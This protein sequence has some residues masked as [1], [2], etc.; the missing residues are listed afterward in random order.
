MTVAGVTAG[1]ASIKSKSELPVKVGAAAVLA[2]SV[3]AGNVIVQV[4]FFSY[5]NGVHCPPTIPAQQHQEYKPL[6]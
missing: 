2:V 4:C 1:L 5:L 3:A 6:Y